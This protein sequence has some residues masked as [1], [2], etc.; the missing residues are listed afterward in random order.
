MDSNSIPQKY[1][2][3]Y[4]GYK[5]DFI[6]IPMNMIANQQT[7]VNTLQSD[8]ID[9][10]LSKMEEFPEAASILEKFTKV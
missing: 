7:V 9:A 8:T 2:V 3:T 5:L 6:Y 1:T 4:N 10:Q